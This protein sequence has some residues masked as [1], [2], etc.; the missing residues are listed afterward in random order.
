MAQTA[1]TLVGD[2]P[3]GA[4]EEVGTGEAVRNIRPLFTDKNVNNYLL[5]SDYSD[6][7]MLLLSCVK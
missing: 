4:M 7:M 5:Y 6:H 3:M 1:Q 2:A